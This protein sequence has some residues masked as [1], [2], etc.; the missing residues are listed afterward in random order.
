[1]VS[2]IPAASESL[3]KG[4]LRRI[5]CAHSDP[6]K[7]EHIQPRRAAFSTIVSELLLFLRIARGPGGG[8]K[9]NFR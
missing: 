8:S 7:E 9:P 6:V 4:R 3:H 2:S 1:M 5:A